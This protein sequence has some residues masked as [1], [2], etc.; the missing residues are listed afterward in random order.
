[1]FGLFSNSGTTILWKPKVVL[2]FQCK[3]LH[4]CQ[5]LAP[6]VEIKT[7]KKKNCC[8]AVSRFKKTGRFYWK[9]LTARSE[10]YRLN[11]I[12]VQFRY[13]KRFLFITCVVNMLISLSKKYIKIHT[14]TR[15]TIR[16]GLMLLWFTDLMNVTEE[17]TIHR[18]NVSTL[19]SNAFI[20]GEMNCNFFG[21]IH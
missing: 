6:L 3:A 5:S 10:N 18:P 7:K 1:M 9:R 2:L 17:V 19:L 15:W 14:A 4:T 21:Y 20:R 13:G 16:H 11:Y 12:A 8:W